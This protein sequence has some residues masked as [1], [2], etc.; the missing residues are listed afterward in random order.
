MRVQSKFQD[1]YDSGLAYGLDTK[2]VYEREQRRIV[3]TGNGA[4]PSDD[5][6]DVMK[7]VEPFVSPCYFLGKKFHD[8]AISPLIIRSKFVPDTKWSSER[9]VGCG[10]IF[11]CG[12]AYPFYVASIPTG[13]TKGVIPIQTYQHYFLWDD[14]FADMVEQTN[15]NVKAYGEWQEKIKLV[16]GKPSPV[17]ELFN[18]PIVIYSPGG[19]LD[20]SPAASVTVNGC[21]KDFRFHKV[22]AP[23]E[24]F[25]EISMY[26]GTMLYPEPP[27]A[28]QSD[29]EKV[30]SHG[31]DPK[32]GFRNKS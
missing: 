20:G 5:W 3:N 29:K 13:K 27:P 15:W 17:N 32:Y 9:Q 11:F 23:H 8:D 21:L 10:V 4:S 18:S 19:A 28:P 31:F 25:Q 30:V 12:R 2:I 22:I 6:K 1:Y 24:A 14:G 16:T 26:L 7:Y